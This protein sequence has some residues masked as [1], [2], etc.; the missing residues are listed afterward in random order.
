MQEDGRREGFIGRVR[1]HAKNGQPEPFAQNWAVV[2]RRSVGEQNCF[3]GQMDG[4]TAE[5]HSC[6]ARRGVDRSRPPTRN[7]QTTRTN[8][9]RQLFSLSPCLS[10]PSSLHQGRRCQGVHQNSDFK[11]PCDSR[12]GSY[13]LMRRSAAFRSLAWA[14]GTRC[15]HPV[16]SSPRGGRSVLTKRSKQHLL[17]RAKTPFF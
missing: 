10:L 4:R 12:G 11:R 2:T 8:D 17:T 16:P 13:R 14:R 15:G 3:F 5:F 6:R 1:S 7:T 9:C